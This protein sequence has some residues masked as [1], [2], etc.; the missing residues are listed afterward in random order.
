[1]PEEV[2]LWRISPK[3]TLDE[4]A[5]KSLD[6][7]ER[8]ERWLEEDISVLSPD[9]LVIGRQ[10][11]TDFGGVIDLLCID[12][13][14]DLVVV[15]LKRD[16]TPREVVAQALDYASWI[17][18]LSHDA[19]VQLANSYLTRRHGES[20]EE[21]FGKWF[22]VELPETL[23]QEHAIII[24]ASIIDE[25]SER[26]VHY[27]SERGI[28]V[29]VATFAYFQEGTA[30]EFLA[31]TFLI[32]PEEVDRKRSSA[33]SKRR[34]NVSYEELEQLADERHVGHLYRQFLDG[35]WG[36][37]NKYKTLSTVGGGGRLERGRRSMLAVVPGE[38]DQ[39]SGLR[40]QLYT[41]PLVDYLGI[42][43]D[44]LASALPDNARPWRPWATDDPDSQG[45]AGYFRTPEEVDRF[46]QLLAR[47]QESV[48]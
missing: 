24:V 25:S 17:C 19:V 20:L 33:G 23:N 14:G 36:R 5:R 45:Y 6:V 28:A 13:Q 16:R 34:K 40:F 43:V 11:T 2:R 18:D 38:S 8:L 1:M 9:L 7:E 21:V 10:V 15:E 22:D 46:L 30:D 3:D 47:S 41:R 32:E 35:I 37:L 31:R 26:I 27:L 42:S 12:A 44:E 48:T 39:E 29:N 4:V